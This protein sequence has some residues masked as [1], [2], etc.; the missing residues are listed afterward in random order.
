MA[1]DNALTRERYT[2]TVVDQL[3]RKLI[4]IHPSIHHSDIETIVG[5]S[6]FGQAMLTDPSTV[7]SRPH[8]YWVNRIF[9][10]CVNERLDAMARTIEPLPVKD[11][12]AL[13]DRNNPKHVE[14]FEDD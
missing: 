8:E 14:W 10:A 1:S 3:E 7:M 9:S 11:G 13:L 6:E 5:Q 12:V 4:K 2:G